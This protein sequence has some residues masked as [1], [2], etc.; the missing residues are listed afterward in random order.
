MDDLI[1]WFR[2]QLDSDEG[3]PATYGYV[4]V[5]PGY[6][7]RISVSVLAD[8]SLWINHAD[9]RLLIG[10]KLIS[11]LAIGTAERSVEFRPISIDENKMLKIRAVNGLAVYRLGRF[12]PGS[13]AYEAE[14]PD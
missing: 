2:A 11:Q 14:W 3:S 6:E 7:G 1:A 4:S 8:G 13:D 5:W 9:P 12:R 10:R